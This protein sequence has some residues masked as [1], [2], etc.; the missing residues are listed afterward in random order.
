MDDRISVS[1]A[2]PTAPVVLSVA[3][4]QPVR[5]WMRMSPS[6]FAPGHRLHRQSVEPFRVP[7]VS[8]GARPRTGRLRIVNSV[9]A[10]VFRMHRGLQIEL[11]E[12]E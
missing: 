3:G 5:F 7:V 1:F 12:Q 2:P 11:P 10:G 6:D 4:G 8:H 9:F